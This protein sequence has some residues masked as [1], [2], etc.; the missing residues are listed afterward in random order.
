MTWT[1][2]DGE[3]YTDAY[4]DSPPFEEDTPTSHTLMFSTDSG[5]TWKYA[6]DNST[7]ATP[8][9]RP[10][11]NAMYIDA[12]VAPDASMPL[13]WTW[14]GSGG[15]SEGSYL[16]R[17]EAYRDAIPLHYAYHQRRIFLKR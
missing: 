4:S 16:L 8:G 14:S 2:W 3:K 12:S 13:S 11:S 9:V 5:A 6:A 17:M 7:A 1:R 15:F 10:S